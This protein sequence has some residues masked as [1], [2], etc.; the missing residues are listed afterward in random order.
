MQKT[1]GPPTRESSRFKG[2]YTA[3]ESAAKV[4]DVILKQLD[5]ELHGGI[6]ISEH[7][8]QEWV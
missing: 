2:P 4:T 5:L 6:L 1:F 3:D 7:G 8:D